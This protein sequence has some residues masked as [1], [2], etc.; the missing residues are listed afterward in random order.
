MATIKK[1]KQII[2]LYDSVGVKKERVLIKVSSELNYLS[3]MRE[4]RGQAGFHG[5]TDACRS[6]RLGKV[7]KPPSSSKR[8]ISSEF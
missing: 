6:L 1:A 7:S 3:S 2:E 5:R 4:K 8:R